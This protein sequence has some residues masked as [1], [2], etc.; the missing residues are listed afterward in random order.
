VEIQKEAEPEIKL[1][2]RVHDDLV[3][4]ERFYEKYDLNSKLTSK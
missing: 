2:I 4:K 3:E 1:V